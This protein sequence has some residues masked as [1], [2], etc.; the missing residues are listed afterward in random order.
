[1][2]ARSRM[3]P[4]PPG[5]VVAKAAAAAAVA[6]CL[7]IGGAASA[8]DSASY[9]RYRDASK[10]LRSGKDADLS[11]AETLFRQNLNDL[12]EVEAAVQ[13]DPSALEVRGARPRGPPPPGARNPAAPPDRRRRR[14]MRARS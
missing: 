9:N 13:A 8:A 10:A 3:H 7:V 11:A 14:S 6:A 12:E 2:A 5:P 4:V 1:M